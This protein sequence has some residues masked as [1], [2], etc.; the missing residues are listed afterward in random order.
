[1]RYFGVHLFQA[2]A[3]VGIFREDLIVAIFEFM[4]E[5]TRIV[6]GFLLVVHPKACSLLWVC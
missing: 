1:M 2:R 3:S 5:Q 6:Q 4:L